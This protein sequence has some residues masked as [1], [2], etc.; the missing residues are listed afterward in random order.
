MADVDYTVQPAADGSGR[1]VL[2]RNADAIIT[3]LATLARTAEPAAEPPAPVAGNEVAPVPVEPDVAQSQSA[4]EQVGPTTTSPGR[5]SFDCDKA[6]QPERD[7]R[8]LRHAACPRSTSTW[9]RN[10]GRAVSS[11]SPEQQA[12]AARDTR[13]LP[14]ATATA[15]PTGSASAM[16]IVGRMREIRDIMEG[17][18]QPRAELLGISAARTASLAAA[19]ESHSLRRDSAVR[20]ASRLFLL[21]HAR[22]GD[23]A[24][25]DRRAGGEARLPGG[26]ADRPQRALRGDAVQRRLHRPRASSRSSARC[27]RWRGRPRS[28]ARRRS[29]GWCCWPRTRQGYANLCKLVSSAHLDRPIERGAARPVRRARGRER[30]ADRADRGRGGRARPAVRR[31]PARQGGGLSRP[32]AGAVPR[33]ALRRAVAPRRCRSRKR[34][35]PR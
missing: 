2:L 35:K 1:C 34:P 9:P 21:H 22:R 13:P 26:R 33:P 12:G 24:Q 27:W 28:A 11:A 30:R 17:R 31:R 5:P 18:W 3:P 19:P 6:R 4:N 7:R 16:P 20:P 25:D 10:I 29:T 8:L 23:G 15:A 32:A 14:R